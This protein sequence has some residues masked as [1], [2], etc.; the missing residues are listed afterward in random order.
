MLGEI[1]AAI[2]ELAEN[3]RQFALSAVGVELDYEVETLP[4]LDEYL[5]VG[6]ARAFA[7]GPS[8]SR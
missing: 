1:P 8:S 7:I 3:C 2:L 6:E 5:R 4:I